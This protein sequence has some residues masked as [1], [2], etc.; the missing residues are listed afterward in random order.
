MSE[1]RSTLEREL[2]RLSP[3]RIPFDELVQRRDRKR[4]NQR[5][6]A[7]VLGLAIAIGVG[8]LGVNAIRSAPPVPADP[9]EP[10][11]DLGI[12]A[13]VAGRIVYY[14]NSSLWGVDPNAASPST[15][16]VRLDPEGTGG[17]D[18]VA[19]DSVPLGW[20][21]DGTKL[22]LLRPDWLRP[23]QQP[24]FDSHLYILH[25]DG[26][27]TRVT[28]GPVGDAAIS[29]DGSRVAFRWAGYGGG[30]YV[31]DA[32]GGEPILIAQTG[33]S[34]TFSP[35][36]TQIAYLSSPPGSRYGVTGEAPVWVVDAD[37]TD[38]HEILAD[39]PAL[40]NAVLR[41]KWSPAGDRIAIYKGVEGSRDDG[42]YTFAPDGSDFTMVITGAV[43][44]DLHWS[45]DGSRIAYTACAS[46]DNCSLA[47]ADAGGSNVRTF[48]FGYS[49]PWHPGAVGGRVKR[50]SIQHRAGSW[51]NGPPPTTT[52]SPAA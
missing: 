4:R 18:R 14:D 31:V 7:G 28:A 48:G 42:I 1:Y 20:S 47:I 16:L 49:G 25:A 30:L 37:G 12:F 40:A 6:R 22:L 34:P 52:I 5:I 13:P 23:E 51:A 11:V 3:P 10:S 38:A 46:E 33:A 35:D 44:G 32:E 8:W 45:P 27:E 2:E 15:T 26:T 43:G 9:P 50:S 19:S 29:P 36:G 24:P 17:A 21:S 41:L 39:E